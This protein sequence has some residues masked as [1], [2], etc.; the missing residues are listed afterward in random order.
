MN[1][2]LEVDGGDLGAIIY[3]LLEDDV[4]RVSS[5]N[6]CAL[7]ITN[8]ISGGDCTICVRPRVTTVIVNIDANRAS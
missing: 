5:S 2:L 8:H 3:D 7:G 1:L 6:S 4:S